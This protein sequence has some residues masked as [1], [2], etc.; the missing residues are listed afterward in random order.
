VLSLNPPPKKPFG[1]KMGKFGQRMAF[2]GKFLTNPQDFHKYAVK[3]H[4]IL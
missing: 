3:F 4:E 2:L 1:P